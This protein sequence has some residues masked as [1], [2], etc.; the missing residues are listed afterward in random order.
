VLAADL[1]RKK[2]I[3]NILQEGIRENNRVNINLNTEKGVYNEVITLNEIKEV[4]DN[5]KTHPNLESYLNELVLYRINNLIQE[6]GYV[7]DENNFDVNSSD[8]YDGY[9]LNVPLLKENYTLEEL[10]NEIDQEVRPNTPINPHVQNKT[11]NVPL[12]KEPG[13]E[14]VPNIPVKAK[15]QK[16]QNPRK[17]DLILKSTFEARFINY[18]MSTDVGGWKAIKTIKDDGKLLI[19]WESV[20]HTAMLIETLIFPADTNKI[21]VQVKNRA[22]QV[23]LNHFFEIY[24]IPTDTFLAERFFRKTLFSL[25]KKYIDT[26]VIQINPFS[27]EFVFWKT[28]NPNF[29]YSFSTPNKNKIILDLISFI[30]TAQK[31]ILDDFFEQNNLKHKQ[32]YLQ[33]LLDSA[34]AAG[35]FRFKREGNEI[36]ILRGSNYKAFL[37]GK[38]RRIV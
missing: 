3:K 22:G 34:E 26:S 33:T 35:I 4:T 5:F 6:Y 2:V 20:E 37:E 7:V 36:L 9:E 30:S 18:E 25:L 38:V 16:T 17:V 23:F 19:T 1:Y 14:M 32:G 13:Q 12:T 8:A 31:P 27:E 21:K 28:D 29:S 11:S 24:R 10:F 15:Q